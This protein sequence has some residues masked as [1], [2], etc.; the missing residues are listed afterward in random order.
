MCKKDKQGIGTLLSNKKLFPYWLLLPAIIILLSLTVFPVLYSF[1]LSFKTFDTYGKS[2]GFAG[3]SNYKD[4]LTSSAFWNSL[5]ITG[6]LTISV[7]S[8]E[9]VI[10]FIFA[11]IMKDGSKFMQYFRWLFIIPMIIAPLVVGI[12][13]RLMLNEDMGIINYMLESIGLGSINWLGDPVLAVLSIIIVDIWQWTPM[14][15]LIIL[16][17]LQSLPQDPYEAAM[18]DGASK[19][20]IFKDITIPLLKPILIVAIVMRTMDALRM[21]DTMFILTGGGPGRATEV[22]SFLMF[23]SALRFSK[24]GF[25]NAGL[26]IVFIFTMILTYYLIKLMKT[27]TQREGGS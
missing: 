16:A 5:G 27:N 22:V 6:F 23:Q 26:I 1:V 2:T 24:Y 21:F 13:F 17:G 14:V 15:F 3:L 20:Q 9:I 7:V 11:M 19:F 12:M 8:L 25:A 10:G 18:L 4:V